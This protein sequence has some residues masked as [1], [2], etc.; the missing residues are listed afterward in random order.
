M[1][2]PRNQL[3]AR[4]GSRVKCGERRLRSFSFHVAASLH[5]RRGCSNHPSNGFLDNRV[6]DAGGSAAK[7]R[8]S[9]RTA[10]RH[11]PHR[12]CRADPLWAPFQNRGLHGGRRRLP[13]DTFPRLGRLRPKVLCASTLGRFCCGSRRLRIFGACPRFWKRPLILLFSWTE[14]YDLR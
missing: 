3:R 11:L 4:A 5:I 1:A 14:G 9:N 13:L 12:F 10:L 8:P 7:L 2:R 6:R